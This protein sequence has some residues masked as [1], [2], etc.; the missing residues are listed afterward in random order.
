[1]GKNEIDN[2]DLQLNSNH[3]QIATKICNVITLKS[4]YPIQHRIL[5]WGLEAMVFF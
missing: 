1:M 4:K 3:T 2:F 5:P